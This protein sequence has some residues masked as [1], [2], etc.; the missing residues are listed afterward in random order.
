MLTGGN[1]GYARNM[2]TQTICIYSKVRHA[3]AASVLTMIAVKDKMIKEGTTSTAD[4]FVL[5]VGTL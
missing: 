3:L 2:T 4:A 1:A 5:T